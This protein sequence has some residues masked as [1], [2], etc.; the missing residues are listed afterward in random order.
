V[1]V[2]IDITDRARQYGYIIWPK[3]H[4]ADVRAT[5]G[6]RDFVRVHFNGTDLGKKR[7]DWKYRR[8]SVGPSQTRTL[9]PDL[10]AFRLS[11]G[12]ADT[13]QVACE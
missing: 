5:L 11:A 6:E 9:S 7:V 13:L 1:S 10:S 12:P 3:K 8:I 2:T 4:E